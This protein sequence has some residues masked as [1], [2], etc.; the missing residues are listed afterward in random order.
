[1]AEGAV[2][3]AA[4]PQALDDLMIAM[5]VVDTLRH[6][7]QLVERE[8]DE[9]GREAELI[10]RL[11]EIYRQQG[12]EVTDEVLAEGV[13]ALRDSRFVYTPAPSGWPRTLFTLWVRRMR[14]SAYAGIVLAAIF[15]SWAAY[16]F[17][18]ARPAR[19]AQEQQRIELEQTLPSAIRK[20]DADVLAVATDPAAKE[21]AATLLSDGERAIRDRDRAGMERVR[22]ELVSLREQV[23]SQYTLTIVSRP[24]EPTG[25]WRRPPHGIDARNYYLIVEA[26]APDGGKLTLPIRNEETGETQV[27]NK[28]GVRVPEEV[29]QAV[30]RDKR[31]DGIVQNNVFGIK[32][33]GMLSVDYKMPFEGGMITK[34]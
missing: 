9:E 8:L 27:V 2:S 30:G 21:R 13:K 7:E 1:M 16:Y 32:Q 5:D 20:A 12:I 23:A 10:A 15:A 26:V 34:W 4:K 11:R 19:L 31:D 6:R 25:V 28:F 14:F 22:S 3:A 17:S 24:G 33:R 18:V 29:Y